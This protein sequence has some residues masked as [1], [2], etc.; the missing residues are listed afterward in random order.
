ML[1]ILY[2]YLCFNSKIT[3]TDGKD[4]LDNLPFF[5]KTVVV[6]L[7]MKNIKYSEN[8]SWKEIYIVNNVYKH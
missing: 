1:S 8:K 6:V 3:I 5:F 2:T 4:T 7:G